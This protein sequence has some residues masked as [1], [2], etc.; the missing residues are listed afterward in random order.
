[1][2]DKNNC[3][4]SALNSIYERKIDGHTQRGVKLEY[5]WTQKKGLN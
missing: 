5:V 2:G 4:E 3:T 1:M